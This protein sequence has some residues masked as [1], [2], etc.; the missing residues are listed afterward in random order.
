MITK[1]PPKDRAPTLIATQASAPMPP[2]AIAGP[3]IAG[4]AKLHQAT[5]KRGRAGRTSPGPPCASL[6]RN[7]SAPSAPP[8]D[9]PDD[10]PGAALSC[11]ATSARPHASRTATTNGPAVAEAA[12]PTAR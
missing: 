1:P 12:A 10:G 9:S 2:A 6:A 4:P 11:T 7:G 8:A 3:A 5:A